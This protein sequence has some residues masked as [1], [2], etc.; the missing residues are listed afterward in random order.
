[1]K[2]I[3]TFTLVLFATT[4][5]AAKKEKDLICH[6]G[7]EE[8]PGGETYL[9]DPGCAPI[10][11][12][13]YFCPD[14]GKIDLI[15]VA[16]A[17]K[18]LSNPNHTYDGIDDYLPEDVGASGEGD[19][20]S[21]GNG[22]DDGCEPP[23]LTS[24]PCWTAEVLDSV[25]GVHSDGSTLG[26]YTLPAP[27]NLC[28]EEGDIEGVYTSNYVWSNEDDFF[29]GEGSGFCQSAAWS[30]SDVIRQTVQF[31]YYGEGDPQNTLTLA[32]LQACSTQV[33]AC[34]T[35]NTSP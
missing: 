2:I 27:N 23:E 30:G 5:F 10:E 4:G 29:G 32:E 1:M 8:G 16:N 34:V 18:H 26:I 21:N 13:G 19:E 35:R 24:C 3:L 6:V 9:D 12:N 31:R 28:S 17:S 15:S 11:E 7:N 25:D 14:A 22:I 20:D 33:Q